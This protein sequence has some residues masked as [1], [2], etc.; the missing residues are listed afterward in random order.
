M[1]TKALIT[2]FLMTVSII[3]P[4]Y[5]KEMEEKMWLKLNIA[6]STA[7]FR[8]NLPHNGCVSIISS[9]PGRNQR[10]T[11]WGPTLMKKGT[12]RMTLPA[13]RITDRSGY[14]E[15]FNV[16]IEASKSIGSRGN[17]ERQFSHPSGVEFDS[18]RKELLIA[19][20]GNDRIVR[21]SP[22]GR[23]ISQHGGFGL[24]FGDTS[25]ERED[26]LDGPYDVAAGG[27]SNFYISDQNNDRI[28]LFD[29]Y[30]TYKGNLYPKNNDRRNRISRPRGI[31]VDSENNIWV[32]EGRVDRVIKISPS[33]DKL[34]EIGGF[35]YSDQ[36]LKDPTQ[37]SIDGAGDIYIADRGKARI[38]VYDRLG[39]FLKEIKNHLKSPSGVEVD[40]DGLILV[41]DDRTNELNLYTPAGIRLKCLSQSNDGIVFRRPSDIALN[42]KWVFMADT[43]NNRI[44]VFSRTKT[45]NTVSWQAKQHVIE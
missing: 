29:A 16:E 45:S 43:G 28:C 39:S 11:L 8:F 21:L 24:A 31:K 17:G 26:S 5:T 13:N 2:I 14:I 1:N 6:S 19:D 42:E 4:A 10:E 7:D 27:F 9:I 41:C 37:I 38:A 36:Q 25:E 40:P 35:G 15:L 18:T 32:V 22:E 12:Y 30:R 23:F 20:T 34:F 33:G 3:S 44:V